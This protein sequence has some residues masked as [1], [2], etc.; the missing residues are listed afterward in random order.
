MKTN[1]AGLGF[2][3][4]LCCFVCVAFA[5]EQE[6]K[7]VAERIERYF[8]NSEG[9][10]H[11]D[12]TN[13]VAMIH[14]STGWHADLIG[15]RRSWDSILRAAARL[16]RENPNLVEAAL[17][18]YMCSYGASSKYENIEEMFLAWS[19][20]MLI[21]RC[22]F[23]IPAQSATDV[24]RDRFGA[25]HK[26]TKDGKATVAAGIGLTFLPGEDE[27]RSYAIPLA[28]DEAGPRLVA[29][30]RS[31]GAGSIA[32]YQPQLEYRFF[33]QQFKFRDGLEHWIDAPDR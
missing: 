3:G 12:V 2:A 14:D 4:A 6:D 22:M 21:L 11:H 25:N 23:E 13:I 9:Y 19:K 33:A 8:E 17:A 32:V 18:S 26:A 15:D 24:M 20:P 31:S 1:Y 7:A 29:T 30:M 27:M 16:Q 5:A 10:S 28:W